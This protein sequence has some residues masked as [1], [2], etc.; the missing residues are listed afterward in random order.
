MNK[1]F[2]TALALFGFVA[3]AQAAN[4]SGG[5]VGPTE[6]TDVYASVAEAK[7]MKDEA[8]VTL[9]GKIVKK[10]GHEKYLFADKTGEITVEIDNKIWR[11]LEITPEDTVVIQGEVDKGWSKV[12]IEVDNIQKVK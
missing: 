1:I 5:F 9:N 11:G 3:S 6:G 10:T 8:Y 12:E 4:Q 2:L 7:N